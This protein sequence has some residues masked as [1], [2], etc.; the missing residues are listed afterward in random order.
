VPFVISLSHITVTLKFCSHFVET[1]YLPVPQFLSFSLFSL[2]LSFMFVNFS[3]L[4][5]S[6]VSLS[7]AWHF[8]R[9]LSHSSH[10][11]LTYLD[12]GKFW[13][14]NWR[15]SSE[16]SVTTFIREELSESA[17]TVPQVRK[18]SSVSLS[19]SPWPF[20]SLLGTPLTRFGAKIGVRSLSDDSLP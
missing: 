6:L 10:Y 1:I 17:D 15:S 5:L 8:L 18:S 12:R 3:P 7:S 11:H 16:V 14:E 4:S 20:S 13:R 2:L 9:S 19:T